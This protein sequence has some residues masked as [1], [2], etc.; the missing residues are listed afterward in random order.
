MQTNYHDHSNLSLAKEERETLRARRPVLELRAHAMKAIRSFFEGQGFLEVFTPVRIPTPALEDYIEAVPSGNQWLRTSPE[1]HMKRMLAAGYEKIYQ[2]G[3]CFRREECGSRHRLEFTML[4]WYRVNG[5]WLDV[6]NDAEQLLALCAQ[7]TKGTTALSFRGTT[8]DLGKP[9]ECI[10]VEEAFRRFADADL[11]SCIASGD[12]E[13]VLCEKV[14]PNLGTRGRPTALT[15]YPLACSGLSQQ[16]PGNPNRVER[17]EVYVCGLELGNAC[18]ELCDAEEQSRR[19]HATWDLRVREG[20]DLYALDQPF[21]DMMRV[22]MP[23]AAGVAIGLDRLIMLLS[24]EDDISS[25][26]AF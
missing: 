15:E 11:D 22:G 19:F 1:F 9:W 21:L 10:P 3:P 26:V 24:G 20:R 25:T 2:T 5:N 7:E 8:I 6:L 23:T 14:E 16:I 18:S 4:E 17:W 13:T 12:F